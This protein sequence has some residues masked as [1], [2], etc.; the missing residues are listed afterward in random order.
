MTQSPVDPTFRSSETAQQIM[1]AMSATLRDLQRRCN[2][3]GLNATGTKTDLVGRLQN[4]WKDRE[5]P[6]PEG[7][8]DIECDTILVTRSELGGEEEMKK[9]AKAAFKQALSE[10]EL[11]VEDVRGELFVG[12][13]RGLNLA[14]LSTRV[15][16]LEDEVASL[17]RE[18]TLLKVHN[19]S[20]ED[21]VSSLTVSLDTYKILRT[22]FIS[23]F[24]RDK[25]GNATDADRRIIEAGDSWA[26]GGD[27]VVDAQLYQSMEGRRDFSTFEKLY[28]MDPSIVLRISGFP[29][30]L[31]VAGQ[32]DLIRP[33]A[34]H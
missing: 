21:R 28:G 33:Q 1:P 26:H 32:A 15:C 8:G 19:T 3:E 7:Q 2:A 4:D 22:G 11:T 13:R 29:C 18:I 20:L 25:L 12:N 14:G 5:A 24:K 16:A 6:S 34:H 17:K 27:A 10:E 30:R 23:S 9:G 31:G